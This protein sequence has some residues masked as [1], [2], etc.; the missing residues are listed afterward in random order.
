[1]KANSTIS[2]SIKTTLGNL[3]L[4]LTEEEV[5]LLQLIADSNHD[6]LDYWKRV[7]EK[8]S[9]YEDLPFSCKELM[10]SAIKKLQDNTE[11]KSWQNIA[12][13][14]ANFLIGLPRYTWTKN[15]YIINQYKKIA[16]ALE[17]EKIEFIAI[18]G[19]G[20]M[21]ANSKLAMMRTSRDIDMLIQPKD[22]EKCKIIFE[23]MGWKMNI[24]QHKLGF[25]NNPVNPHA[26]GFHNSERIIDLDVHFSAIGGPKAYAEEFTKKLWERKVPSAQDSTLYIA[27]AEDR[28]IIAAAN[29]YKLHNWKTG[30]S[31]KYL[32][33]ALSITTELSETE[34]EKARIHGEQ[35]LELG[36]TMHQ[37]MNVLKQIRTKEYSFVEN[38]N[39]GQKRK[40]EFI[41]KKSFIMK[42]IYLDY[43]INLSKL[44]FSGTHTL[45]TCYFIF[46]RTF[47]LLIIRIPQKIFNYFIPKKK[48]ETK[49]K[50]H[51]SQLK[52]FFLAKTN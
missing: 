13:K 28:L 39:I 22:W 1:V 5:A 17:A 32:Y 50:E 41:V 51:N 14:N 2:L 4:T 3:E 37:L 30:Q 6:E 33:D 16:A 34:I 11:Q 19:V 52:W 23:Q 15:H 43:F 12:A 21:L 45:H 26:E 10:P 20:E 29:A 49:E 25:L 36:N 44:L 9:D 24:K 31:C 27:C 35:Y 38:K 18:K 48:L 7:W 47:N 42:L 46:A 40:L 8:V